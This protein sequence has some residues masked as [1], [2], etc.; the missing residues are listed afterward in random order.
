[1]NITIYDLPRLIGKLFVPL[2]HLNGHP[3]YSPIRI[4]SYDIVEGDEMKS[5]ITYQHCIDAKTFTSKVHAYL[6]LKA[7]NQY[8]MLSV[9][10]SM[11]MD[12][13]LGELE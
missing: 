1:M 3:S 11:Y 2:S 8:Y 4:L 6:V 10:G 7:I 12:D 9:D 5:Y 13:D